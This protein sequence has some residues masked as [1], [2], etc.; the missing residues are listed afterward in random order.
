MFS[1]V[2]SGVNFRTRNFP[3]LPGSYLIGVLD[4]PFAIT[5]T[6]SRLPLLVTCLLTKTCLKWPVPLTALNFFTIE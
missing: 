2:I 1:E 5:F 3:L 6:C 4:A